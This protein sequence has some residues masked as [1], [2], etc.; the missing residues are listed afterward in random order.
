MK[1]LNYMNE[2]FVMLSS[3]RL[4]FLAVFILIYS[5]CTSIQ[6]NFSSY[7]KNIW[8][9]MLEYRNNNFENALLHFDKAFAIISDENSSDYFFAA[10]AALKL[11]KKKVA[12]KYII[13]GIQKTNASKEYYESFEEF[14]SFRNDSLF[15]KIGAK[16]DSLTQTFYKRLPNEFIYREVESLVEKDQQV[17][18]GN[19]QNQPLKTVDSINI[20]RLIDINKNH[21]WFKQGW[22]I[23]WH[24]RDTYGETNFI[25][26]FYVPFINSQIESG[27]IR[28]DFWAL[29]EEEKSIINSKTQIYGLYTSQYEQF[30]IKDLEHVDELR[31]KKGLPPLWYLHDVYGVELPK[32]YKSTKINGINN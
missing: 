23:L 15:R 30:P 1:Q 22:I 9:A 13:Y 16:Y 17:R 24:Q 3:H 8:E 19:L 18:K 27:K 6:V 12:E 5:S 2:Y 29:F 31:I 11:N 10:A 4:K 28:K 25:W 14:N 32:D 20:N 7:D 21:G 26:D